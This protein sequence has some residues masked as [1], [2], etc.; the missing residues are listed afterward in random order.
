MSLRSDAEEITNDIRLAE[1]ISQVDWTPPSLFLFSHGQE[2]GC[3]LKAAIHA[4]RIESDGVSKEFRPID[5]P[6]AK[7][8]LFFVGGSFA[9]HLR[10]C[11]SA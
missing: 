1:L 8:G 11:G 5:V 4:G 7:S 2:P 3:D 9:G 10:R 6:A